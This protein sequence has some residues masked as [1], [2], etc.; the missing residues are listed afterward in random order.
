MDLAASAADAVVHFRSQKDHRTEELFWSQFHSPDR[1][2]PLT[3]RLAAWA[4][5]NR[6]SGLAMTDIVAH[7]WPERPKV[8][9]YFGLMQ[10]ISWSGAAH[11][12]DEA[13][14]LHRWR[15]DGP[16]PCEDTLDRD[17]CHRY[18]R[19]EFGRKA[20]YPPSTILGKLCMALV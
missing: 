15:A 14:G 4:E 18:C 10:Q 12:G 3:D 17:G 11:Q 1:S 16:C 8:T 20:G 19:P 13:V 5:L 9:S 6:L 2:L 7:V